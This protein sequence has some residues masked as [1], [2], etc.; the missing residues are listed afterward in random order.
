MLGRRIERSLLPFARDRW[1]KA[2]AS[3]DIDFAATP[4]RRADVSAWADERAR[5]PIDPEW[6]PG[7][8]LGVLPIEDGGAAVSLVV[9]HPVVDAGGF[10][11]AV[12]DAAEGK[13]RD[14]GYP[15]AG[16][17]TLSRALREDL[18]QTVKDLPD[19]AQALGAAARPTW[20]DRKGFTI[21]DQ[22]GTTFPEYRR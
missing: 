14:L 20:P 15:P 2:A 11:Q 19:M 5:L 18:Q 17:R 1:V 4:R 16:S 7:W 12:A 9:S 13:T 21:I 3:E 8:H 22:S 10:G 6:G